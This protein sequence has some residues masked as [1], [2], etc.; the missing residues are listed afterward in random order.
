MAFQ[1]RIKAD[2]EAERVVPLPDGDILVGRSRSAQIQLSHS[3]VSGRHLMLHTDKDSVIVENLSSHGS[4]TMDMTLELPTPLRPGD[5]IFLGNHTTITLEKQSADPDGNGGSTTAPGTSADVQPDRA[6]EKAQSRAEPAFDPSKTDPGETP[7]PFA[8]PR[9]APA[10][11]APDKTVIDRP[12]PVPADLDKTIL[13]EPSPVRPPAAKPAPDETI[14]DGPSPVPADLD[15]TILDEPSP[16]RP[17]AAKP[18]K[19]IPEA[20]FDMRGKAGAA[21]SGASASVPAGGRPAAGQTVPPA[22]KNQATAPPEKSDP[23]K[24]N[25]MQTRLASEDEINFL[26]MQD[27]KRKRDKKL[28]YILGVAGLIA[29]VMA[30]YLFKGEAPEEKLTWPRK[31][32]GKYSEKPFDLGDG[33]FSAGRF[34]LI[35]PLVDT[36]EKRRDKNGDLVI[37]TRIGRD[38]DVTMRMILSVRKSSEYL[39][40]DRI[41]TFINWISEISQSGGHWNFGQ[42]SDLFFIGKNN[43]LPCLNAVYS[44]EENN[45]SWYG[46]VLFFRNGNERIVRLVEIPSSERLRGAEFLSG[47]AFIF[48]SEKFVENHWEGAAEIYSGNPE[49]LLNEAKGLLIKMSPS[50]WGKITMLLR[51]VLVAAVESGNLGL[52]EQALEQL[53]KLRD[54]QRVWYNTQ[55]IAYLK[56]KS[57]GN[58][59]AANII[60]DSCLSVF[61]SPDDLRH[62]N[63]T[64]NIWE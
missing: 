9:Q 44:R 31:E 29:I 59:R 39:H 12:S 60:R 50:T 21:V 43:G 30:F 53:R 64:R 14:I 55:C 63:I 45:Q 22:E 37:T 19:T 34:S 35:A 10:K 11:P 48:T 27:R 18:D 4:R 13:D 23:Y 15:K 54:N 28:K 57:A 46:E 47:N 5:T 62:L 40:E 25:V 36:T 61:S 7:N 17:S 32:N 26:R 8:S 1:L 49:E 51:S 38:R 6:E 3:D 58:T 42:I 52:K 41:Q 56:E 16:V 2:N 20:H 33:G 24:T